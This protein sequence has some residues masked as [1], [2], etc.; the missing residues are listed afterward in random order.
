MP[1]GIIVTSI[2][3]SALIFSIPSVQAL[4]KSSTNTFTLNGMTV[5]VTRSVVKGGL[6]YAG[7]VVTSLYKE[8]FYVASITMNGVNK[9]STFL[10][11]VAEDYEIST[12]SVETESDK[13][14]STYGLMS[15]TNQTGSYSV[16]VESATSEG[17]TSGYVT[18]DMHAPVG[19]CYVTLTPLADGSY[20]GIV[21]LP[22]GETVDPGIYMF[23]NA[24]HGP[25]WASYALNGWI[26]WW[27]SWEAVTLGILAFII[28]IINMILLPV[29][30]VSMILDAMLLSA[31]LFPATVEPVHRTYWDVIFLYGAVPIFG[32]AGFYTNQYYLPWGW[33]HIAWTYIP[34]WNTNSYWGGSWHTDVWPVGW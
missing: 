20:K 27:Y 13:A 1:Q 18:Q 11:I 25:W 16:E 3:L 5:T 15:Y 28:T 31:E 19:K 23:V 26:L 33:Q 12:A 17:I 10:N 29:M 2:I 30:P 14:S 6:V 22:T 4:P 21:T 24:W 34:V 8:E 7:E 32:E 9:T